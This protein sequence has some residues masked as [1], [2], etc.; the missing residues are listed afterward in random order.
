MAWRGHV[1]W[2]VCSYEDGA[3]AWADTQRRSES[4]LVLVVNASVEGQPIGARQ[5]RAKWHH[6]ARLVEAV[7]QLHGTEAYDFFWFLD[8]DISFRGFE[9]LAFIHRW[10]CAAGAAGPPVVA[11]PTLREAPSRKQHFSSQVWTH[12]ASTYR[13]C[14]GGELGGS[15]GADACF[16][17]AALALRSDWLEQWG[18]LVDAKF[19]AWFLQQPTA[20]RIR[21]AQ[22]RHNSDFGM[23]VT[24]CG[25]AEE[26]LALTAGGRVTPRPSCVVVTVPV[27]HDDARTQGNSLSSVH[28]QGGFKVLRDAGLQRSQWK[29]RQPHACHGRNCTPHPWWRYQPTMHWELPVSEDGV[30]M[31]R[32]CVST[33]LACPGID[34][35][36]GLPDGSPGGLLPSDRADVHHATEGISSRCGGLSDL[37][38]SEV[39]S[40]FLIG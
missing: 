23:D 39:R 30:A 2:A 32:A 8:E 31:V 29:M 10:A 17:R 25:A 27:T 36:G 34:P 19:L 4:Q 14:L 22:L 3:E 5:R 15:Y 9:L 11:S 13:L 1:K 35:G 26:W 40:E 20:K 24:W 33:R 7:W 18:A 16:L 6:R 21:A 38:W 28:V 12:A 37:W